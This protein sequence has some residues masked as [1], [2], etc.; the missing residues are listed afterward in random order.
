[1]TVNCERAYREASRLLD[2]RLARDGF[3]DVHLA[4]AQAFVD[5]ASA[6]GGD[7]QLGL[8]EHPYWL[9]RAM[10][11]EALGDSGNLSVSSRLALLLRDQ[12]KTV[13]SRAREALE[14]LHDRR[15]SD[16]FCET[17]IDVV[18]KRASP[19]A[20]TEFDRRAFVSYSRRDS[21]FVDRLIADLKAVP[22][23]VWLDLLEIGDDNPTQ[24]QLVHLLES[25]VRGSNHLLLVLSDRSN[26]SYWVER[27]LRFAVQF[28]TTSNPIHVVVIDLSGTLPSLLAAY[29]PL[30]RVDF[31]SPD[32]YS[33]SFEELAAALADPTA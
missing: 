14:T 18:T 26:Q 28:E 23:P 11:C 27:E 20:R 19:P 13:R 32:S 5:A 31:S 10:T 17:L 4:E 15:L 16:D 9:V 24:S 12:H 2:G 25:G 21:K 7:H 22:V 29:A 30:T 33:A 3:E 6:L 8:L 1:V